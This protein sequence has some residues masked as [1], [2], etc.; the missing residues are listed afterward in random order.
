MQ[1]NI[2]E[3]KNRLSQLIKSAQAGE[4]IVIANRGEPVVRLVPV[5]KTAT[6]AKGVGSGRAIL[7]WLSDHPVP[8]YARRSAEEIDAA[9]GDE[10]EAWD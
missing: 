8:A 6:A 10:R 7:D 4:E 9:I 1:V 5:V 2:L 3:A